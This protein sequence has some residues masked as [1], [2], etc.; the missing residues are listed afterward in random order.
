M[1]LIAFPIF[2]HLY[3]TTAQFQIQYEMHRKSTLADQVE[4]VTPATSL[5]WLKKGKEILYQGKPFDIKSYKEYNG[6]ATIKGYVDEK[7]H[8]LIYKIIKIVTGQSNTQK[9]SPLA[10]KYFIPFYKPIVPYE[11]LANSCSFNS[12][13]FTSTP[14]RLMKQSIAIIAPPP[15]FHPTSF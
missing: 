9:T 1:L 13:Y 10:Y 12:S 11:A 14:T 6:I 3:F 5:I 8:E 2:L 15:R 4:I 7:E